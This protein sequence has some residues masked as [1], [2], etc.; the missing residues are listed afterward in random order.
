MIKK[1]KDLIILLIC[2]IAIFQL[3]LYTT[4]PAFKNDDSPETITSAYT[5]GISHPPGYP[6]FTMAVKIFTLLPIGSPAFRVN[7]FSIFLALIVLLLS[8]FVI[9]QITLYIF[10]YE[11]KIVN[12]LSVFIL[13]LSYIFWNQAIE[14]KG[15]IYILNLMFF[16]ILIFLSME[17]FKRFN[18]KYLYLMSFVYGL[19]LATHWPS[20]IILL[21]IFGY[22]FLKYGTKVTT[23]NI[24][25]AVMLLLVGLSPYIYLAVRAETDGIFVFMAKPNTWENFW[26]TVLRSGYSPTELPATTVYL[27]QIKEFLILF[28]NNYSIL[29]LLIFAGSYSLLRSNKKIYYF[30]LSIFLLNTFFVLIFNRTEKRLLSLV[31]IFLMPAQYILIVYIIAGIYFLINLINKKLIKSILFIILSGITVCCGFIDF[32]INNSRNNY[33]SY[34]FGNNILKTLDP[35]SF[36]LTDSDYYTMPI[37][38]FKNVEHRTNDIKPVNLYSLQYKWG[39]NAFIEKYGQISFMQLDWLKNLSEI[40]NSY[41]SK[42]SIYITYDYSKKIDSNIQN[43]YFLPEGIL[44]KISSENKNTPTHIYK[45]YSYR[46]IFNLKD[47]YDNGLVSLYS[48]SMEK[49]ARNFINEKKFTEARELYNKVLMFAETNDN[50]GIYFNVAWGYSQLGDNNQAIICLKKSITI[51]RDYWQAYTALGLIYYNDKILPLAKEM[52]EK[53]IQYGSDNKEWLQ[54]SINAIE[55]GDTATQ[56]DVMFNQATGM[57]SKGEYNYALNIYEYLLKNNYYRTTDIYKNIGVYNF[58]TNNF[59]EALKYFQKAME[60][61]KNASIYAYIA[62]TYYKSGQPNKALNTLREAMQEFGNDPQLTNLYN[63]IVQAQGINKK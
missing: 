7:L 38:Y 40:I 37:V 27:N 5:L 20:M 25:T 6:L 63:Q 14:A 28:L 56:Y 8:Y 39:I 59:V 52:F 45:S 30:Y 24:I 22:L 49:Q 41:I 13:G 4:F 42:N 53:A 57:L 31:D 29:W 48:K 16:A 23:K 34:D 43:N 3:Y 58:Q 2:L 18:I 51:K 44:F 36:C 33:F 54:K 35:D 19:S 60:K 15:G 26:W 62:Y 17:L 10:N 9:R 47:D 32:K 11:N 50:E 21:P 46:G 12:F 1:Y 55:N 61:D